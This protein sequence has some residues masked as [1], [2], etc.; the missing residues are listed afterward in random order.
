M[1][2]KKSFLLIICTHDNHSGLNGGL[3]KGMPM[4]YEHPE[5]VNIIQAVDE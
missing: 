4:S 1:T 2:S 3:P 5:S